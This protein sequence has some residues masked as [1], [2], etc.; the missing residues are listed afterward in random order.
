MYQQRQSFGVDSGK[1][2]CLNFMST[3]FMNEYILVSSLIGN[4]YIQ[5]FWPRNIL[6]GIF[7]IS[8]WEKSAPVQH[9]KYEDFTLPSRI[10]FACFSFLKE[11]YVINCY[12]YLSPRCLSFRN[13]LVQYESRDKSLLWSTGFNFI[14]AYYG[15]VTFFWY[16]NTGITS[17]SSLLTGNKQ[18]LRRSCKASLCGTK[19][20]WYSFYVLVKRFRSDP[21][22]EIK[23]KIK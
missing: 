1:S 13:K 6:Y 8:C 10:L 17:F 23:N 15:V 21:I 11:M 9:M 18:Q 3:R 4:I 14:I 12:Y 2:L 5:S 7:Q 19:A 20:T 22:G 16:R